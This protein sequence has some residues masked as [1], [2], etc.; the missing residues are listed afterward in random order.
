MDWQNLFRV[1]TRSGSLSEALLAED[2]DA[3]TADVEKLGDPA[4]GESVYRRK[5]VACMSCHAIGSAGPSDWSEFGS[6]GSCS[7]NEVFRAVDPGAECGNR[8][9]L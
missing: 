4:R 2:I 1:A 3:L 5:A 6:R 8:R 9:A 7:K